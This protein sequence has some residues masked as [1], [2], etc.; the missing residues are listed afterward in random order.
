MSADERPGAA[1]PVRTL[2][3]LPWLLVALVALALGL[4]GLA[5]PGLPTTPFVLLAAWAAARGSPRL[6][7]WL[8]ARP[9]LG[10]MLRAWER[11][12]AI[13]RAAKVASSAAMGVTAAGLW[14][15]VGSWL[16]PASAT[17]ALGLV[18]AWIW[19][20]PEP[21]SGPGQRPAA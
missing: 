5:L 11:E 15:G 18:A 3:T 10:P 6:H 9:T 16:C 14:V 17:L 1:R 21:R 20:R 13:P 2:L 7:G 4:L 8:L 19:R 12:R